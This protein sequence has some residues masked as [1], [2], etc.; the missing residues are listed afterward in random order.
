MPEISPTLTIPD[1]EL[2]L[3]YIRASG[4]GGQN[5]NKVSSA[6]QLRFHILNSPSLLQEVKHRLVKLGGGR[7]TNDGVLVI[8]AKRYRSQEDN[9]LDAVR[10]FVVLVQKALEAPKKRKP[11]SPGYTAK[12]ARL[13]DKKARG[14][15]KRIRR[16][17][18]D[19][20]E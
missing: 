6:V 3:D 4:P 15:L 13:A 10:R 18:P 12:A 20:W 5:V 9:R 19:D 11:T 14:E 16:Y 7:V 1:D 17:N 8:E 2:Q